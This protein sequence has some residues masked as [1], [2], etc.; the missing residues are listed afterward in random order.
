M[1][2]ALWLF[3]PIIILIVLVNYIYTQDTVY[4]APIVNVKPASFDLLLSERGTLEASRF[5]QVVSPI[6]SNRAKIVE[7]LPEG[8]KVKQ[9]QI[10]ARFDIKSFMDDATKWKYSI[11]EANAALVQ[12]EKELQIQQSRIDESRQNILS[13][14]EIAQ[15]NLN[16]I[17]WGNGEIKLQELQQTLQQE[18]RNILMVEAELDDYKSLYKRGYISKR[19]CDTIEDKLKKAYEQ[20]SA[21]QARLN[22]YTTYDWPKQIKEQQIRLKEL[23]DKLEAAQVQGQFEVENKRAQLIKANAYLQHCEEELRVAKQNIV[24]CDVRAP[25]GGTILY[26]EIPKNGR[27]GKVEIG[28][29]IWFNQ[30]FMQIPDTEN[31]IVR[32]MIK[33]IDLRHIKIGHD[34]NIVLDAYPDITFHGK[35]KFIDSIAKERADESIKYFEVLLTI[36]NNSDKTLRSGMSA[37]VQIIYKQV[38]NKLCIPIEAIRQQQSQTYVLMATEPPQ[39]RNIVLGDIGEHEAVVLDGLQDGER[40]LLR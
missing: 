1:K 27:K 22:N 32:T 28:D 31:M 19:E 34:V 12:A 11:K 18:Q 9:D 3:L 33:E 13:S 37:T 40:V 4:N 38:V 16:D 15:I 21:A 14:I 8:S 36:E 6:L 5:V 17:Q 20:L 29:S 25:I 35:V 7:M 24:A 10:I 26:H 39:K 30:S 23:Q 2:S